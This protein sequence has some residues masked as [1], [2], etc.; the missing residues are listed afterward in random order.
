MSY[1]VVAPLVLAKDREGK[2]HHRYAEEVIEWLPP[3]QA[4]HF[5]DTGLVVKVGGAAESAN[6]GDGGP[7][8]P[9]QVAPKADWVDFAV[10]NGLTE[11]EAEAMTKAELIEQFG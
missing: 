9:K 2:T 5:L 1:K 10:A 7:D 11:D 8:K 4:A 3:D 6:G